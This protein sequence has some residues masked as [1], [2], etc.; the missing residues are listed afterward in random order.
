MKRII[1]LFISFLIM[2]NLSTADASVSDDKQAVEQAVERLRK[3]MIDPDKATFD[4]LA[5]NELSYG[6]SGGKIEDK[7]AFMDSFLSGK[8]DFVSIDLTEQTVTVVGNTAIVR[9]LLTAETNDGGN[10]A[11]VKI[12][13]I[14]VWVKEKG[15]WKLLARQAVK[16][17]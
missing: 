3:A 1:L 16:R 5:A 14:L 4:A 9:H 10:P 8:S 13:V 2:Q 6:H 17:A 15:E 11:H 7:A 12:G